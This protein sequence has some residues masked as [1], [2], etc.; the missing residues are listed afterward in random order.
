MVTG[1]FINVA[2]LALESMLI[3]TEH[4]Y[5]TMLDIQGL[6]V[7]I[8]GEPGIGKSEAALGLIA[9]GYSLVADDITLFR[10]STSA[11][12]LVGTAPETIKYYMEIRGLGPVHIP[13]LFGMA[14]ITLE[15]QLD[16][17]IALVRHP[18]TD[19]TERS[20]LQP[21]TRK[22]LDLDIPHVTLPVAAG[23]DMSGVVEVAA[24]NH[25][26]RLLGH[27]APKEFNDRLIRILQEK[28]AQK[29][30]KNEPIKS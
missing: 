25:K 19:E 10:R 4:V 8:T 9:K 24:M 21:G 12:I 26:L 16:L 18:S 20:G 2:T 22:I 17:I 28:A 11:P 5:G 7:L 29:H 27:D 6:G 1:R 23:R 14:A 3:S 15:K 30:G 13:S